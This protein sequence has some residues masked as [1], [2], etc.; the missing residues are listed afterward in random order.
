MTDKTKAVKP[1]K[2]MNLLNSAQMETAIKSIA[3]R[4]A[5]FQ[6]DVHQCAVSALAHFEQHGDHTLL[7]K[8]ILALPKSSRTNA[9]VAWALHFGNLATNDDKSTRAKS[10]VVKA[11]EARTTPFDVAACIAAPFWSFKA[12]EGVSPWSFETF[13]ASLVKSLTTAYGKATDDAQKAKL[14]AA[15]VAMGKAPIAPAPVAEPAL[16]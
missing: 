10:I 11:S 2:P 16:M 1:A 13:E 6:A 3:G 8:L 5:K 15:L 9:L 7:N 12:T 4:G 14:N